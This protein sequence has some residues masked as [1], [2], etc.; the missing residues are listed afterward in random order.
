MRDHKKYFVDTNVFL[1]VIVKENRSLFQ[2][3]WDFLSLVKQGHITACTSN[4][5]LSEINWVLSSFY[6]F[7]KQQVIQALESILNLKNLKINDKHDSF[8]SIDLYKKH[9]VKFVDCL[10]ASNEIFQKD[11]VIVSYDK[12]FDKLG[13]VRV[14]PGNFTN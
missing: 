7:N 2:D 5:V 12:D 6:K 13:V 1:R 10:I 3:S 14:E 9:K 11:T 4:L 8:L